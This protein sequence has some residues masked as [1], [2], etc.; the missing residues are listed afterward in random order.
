MADRIVR[1]IHLSPYKSK[2]NVYF[3]TTITVNTEDDY[4]YEDDDD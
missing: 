1:D 4:D 2:I 3:D